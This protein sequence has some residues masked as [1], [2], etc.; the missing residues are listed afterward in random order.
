M[1]IEIADIIVG[2]APEAARLR[3][4]LAPTALDR[5]FEIVRIR[6]MG[7][8]GKRT[9]QV[10][11]ER[12][13]GTMDIGGCAELSRAFSAIMDV[14][15]PI[16]NAYNLEVSSPGIDRPLTREKDFARFEGFEAK[17]E[18]NTLID[19][20]RRFRGILEG[21]DGREVLLRVALDPKAEP[22]VLGFEL[23]LISEAKLVLTDDMLRQSTKDNANAEST[24]APS[25]ETK[26]N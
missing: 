23:G 12:A 2:E 21:V 20:R 18:T 14:E 3:A 19:G 9:L 6:F 13:D 4:L 5:G 17:L 8:E 24:I 11:A 26:L 7:G 25:D 10:M 1:A 22:Q 16:A 15:D